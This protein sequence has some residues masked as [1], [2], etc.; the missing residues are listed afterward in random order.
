MIVI[1]LHISLGYQYTFHYRTFIKKLNLLFFEIF[2]I[3]IL[4]ENGLPNHPPP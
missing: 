4:I 2:M 3:L 1:T